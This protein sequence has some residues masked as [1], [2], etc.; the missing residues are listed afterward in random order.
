MRENKRKDIK[1]FV[2]HIIQI[3]E[4][5]FIHQFT[6]QTFVHLLCARYYILGT[7]YRA[8]NQKKA[9]LCLV[10]SVQKRD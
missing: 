8:V 5:S 9:A 7:T 6:Q 1:R 2:K 10:Y 3:L 4:I